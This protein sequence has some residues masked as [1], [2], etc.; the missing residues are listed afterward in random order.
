MALNVRSLATRLLIPLH[1]WLGIVIGLVVVLWFASGIAMIYVGGMPELTPRTRL[2][3]LDALDL[4]RVR[5]TP[6]QAAQQLAQDGGAPGTPILLTVLERPAY[7]FPAAGA[8]IFAASLA[9]LYAW[10]SKLNVLAVVVG[11]AAAGAAA[12]A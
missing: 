1:R 11:S 4:S 3:H 12:F 9:L 2:D 6:A 10:K 8:T 7:R 5:L